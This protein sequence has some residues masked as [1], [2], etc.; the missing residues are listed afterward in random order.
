MK[1]RLLELIECKKC[2]S[3]F[4][5]HTFKKENNEIKDGVLICPQC[6]QYHYIIDFI[7]RILPKSIYYNPQF[8]I[9]YNN[10]IKKLIKTEIYLNEKDSLK[11]LKKSNIKYFG[12]EWVH[13]DRHGFDDKTYNKKFEKK[14]F[15][16]KTLLRKSEIKGKLILDAGCGNGRYTYQALNCGAEVVGFDLGPGV[17]SAYNNTKQFKKAHIIQTDI[18]NL[19]FK[20]NIFD[21]VFTIGVIHHTG[22]SKKALASVLSPLKEKGT[23][24]IT[25]YHKGN[26][27][28]EFNDWW[29]RKI[30]IRMSV[31]KLMKL[32]R[33]LAKTCRFCGLWIEKP[34]NLLFR[35]E[36]NMSIMFDWYSAPIAHHHTYPEV[37]SWCKQLGIELK[38]DLRWEKREWIRNIRWVRKYLAPDWAITL[39]GIKTSEQIK[40]L[41]PR[42]IYDKTK[43]NWES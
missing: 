43:I 1:K 7:P 20:K 14:I 33:F 29:F 2:K 15:H 21:V 19:P 16:E 17:E 41:S 28:W 26:V 8:K 37:Y 4:D 39:K 38:E 23:I 22:N 31:P 11:K 36:P 18:F 27:L 32:A 13:F 40:K 3:D 24:A 10:K 42:H 34:V 12:H 6:K 25:C 9:R 5:L 35:W 30:T